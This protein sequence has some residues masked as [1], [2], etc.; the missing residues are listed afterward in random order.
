MRVL[1]L[2]LLA[3]VVLSAVVP[4]PVASQTTPPG[5]GF[6][7]RVGGDI[8]VA[9]SEREGAV[10]VIRGN[11]RVAGTV[12]ALIVIDGE[13]TID[14]GRVLELIVIRGHAR[15]TGGGSVSGDVHLLDSSIDVT[16]GSR[17]EG[18][19]ERG[20]GR[21]FARQAFTIIAL[22]G[23][24]VLAALVA[25]GI[26]VALVAPTE[27]VATGKLIRAETGRVAGATAL[28]FLAFP[29]L[30]LLLVPTIVGLPFGL[31]YLVFVL[32]FLGFLGLIVAG[33]WVGFALL[34][35]LGGADKAHHPVAAA[36][37]GITILVLVG[38]IPILGLLA[39]I[40]VMLGAGAL[41]LRATR[42]VSRRGAKA[43][44]RAVPANDRAVTVPS[45]GT[46]G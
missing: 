34:R 28:L 24:G 11:G 25:A 43:D 4:L 29:I 33:T 40:L 37:L 7:F 46:A 2:G 16:P 6:R 35:Q 9:A 15:L 20:M 10:V 19:V 36:S 26:L 42:A 39:S 1:L 38:R 45:A 27:L 21:R 31:G 13:A 8:E 30:A 3:S 32:P 5:S 23:L 17:V 44:D 14:G 41:L 18:Q 22:I 12:G